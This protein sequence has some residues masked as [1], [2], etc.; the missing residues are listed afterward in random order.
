M[1]AGS[2]RMQTKLLALGTV[3][4][5]LLLGMTFSGG[6]RNDAPTLVP[7]LVP[8]LESTAEIGLLEVPNVPGSS[9]GVVISLPNGQCR[10]TVSAAQ[11]CPIPND[12]SFVPVLLVETIEVGPES[13]YIDWRFS[14]S[15]DGAHGQVYRRPSL[16]WR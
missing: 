15:S 11:R 13:A 8:N 16:L 6:P 2:S 9:T 3:G 1:Q 7:T 5:A 14:P 12:D 4:L 10:L